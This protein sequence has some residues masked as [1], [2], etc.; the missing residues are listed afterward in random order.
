MT[1][2]IKIKDICI[3]NGNK[4]AIQ[5]MT[6]TDT[7]DVEKTVEQI[8]KLEEAGCDIVRSSVYDMKAAYAFKDITDKINIPLVADVHFDYK[9]AIAAV[10]NGANKLRINPGNI[11]EKK[12]I[13]MVADCAKSHGI[14]IRIGVNGGSLSPYIREKFGT[15][16]AR[17]LVESAI[18]N[19]KLLEDVGFYDICVSVKSSNVVKMINAFRR[20]SQSC[21]YPLHLGVTEAGTADIG[22][23]KNAIGIGVLLLE[24]IGDTIRVSLTGDPVEEIYAA[25]N[26]LR[27]IGMFD[28]GVEIISCP[29]CARTR[30]PLESI[31][32]EVRTLPKTSKKILKLL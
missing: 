21:D 12:Y 29:M 6:T 27:S 9:L 20:L 24:G 5:S 17:A 19:I 8:K 31:V 28:K 2:E 1:K 3:G 11:T 16:S 23:T 4:I 32:K 13:K 26:I 10:E 18:E 15:S 14:P 7:A 22:V 25:Q 30:I